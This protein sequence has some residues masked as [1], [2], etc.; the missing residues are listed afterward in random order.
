MRNGVF[1]KAKKLTEFIIFDKETELEE[2]YTFVYDREKDKNYVTIE[3][4]EHGT[5]IKCT[6]KSCSIHD[7]KYLCSHKLAV[8]L[9]KLLRNTE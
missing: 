1:K 6:C 3:K 5:I 8:I 2:Y 7:N 4:E 9:W